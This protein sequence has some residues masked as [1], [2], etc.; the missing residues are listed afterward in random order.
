M[1]FTQFLKQIFIRPLSDA[2]I[3][4]SSTRHGREH[5]VSDAINAI[6]LSVT[7]NLTAETTF[8]RFF[9]TTLAEELRRSISPTQATY[10]SVG[11][12]DHRNLSISPRFTL[13]PVISSWSSKSPTLRH[14][15]R[16]CTNSSCDMS[17]FTR[18]HLVQTSDSCVAVVGNC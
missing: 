1:E 13:K 7:S 16:V 11:A 9:F 5:M 8:N 12:Q 2:Q 4:S 18:L 15:E 6:R 10:A 17:S 14:S 3:S